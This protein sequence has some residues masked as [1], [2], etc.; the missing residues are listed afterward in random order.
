MKSRRRRD[1]HRLETKTNLYL[2]FKEP[3]KRFDSSSKKPGTINHKTVKTETPYLI[4]LIK[5]KMTTTAS[6][7]LYYHNRTQ[8]LSV[9]APSASKTSSI[10]LI[11]QLTD[12]R[13]LTSKSQKNMARAWNDCKLRWSQ[14]ISP[15]WYQYSIQL[16]FC[17]LNSKLRSSNSV[18]VKTRHIMYCHFN[19]NQATTTF[20]VRISAL[21]KLH[22][23][24]KVGYGS[25]RG[26]SY[27][28]ERRLISS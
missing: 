24:N 26:N 9:K 20:Q 27:L 7:L 3:K 28:K 14:D 12:H 15:S 1:S 13:L 2:S 6:W 4:P 8:G 25:D 17:H 21:S 5:P 11:G 19:K 10:Q 16:A 22:M 23:P 18:P